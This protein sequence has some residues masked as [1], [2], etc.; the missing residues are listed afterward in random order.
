MMSQGER[1]GENQQPGPGNRGIQRG[2]GEAP[3]SLSRE[4]TDLGTNNIEGVSNTDLSRALPG[5]M[6]GETVI[7]QGPETERAQGSTTGGGVESI[8]S[9]GERVWRDQ[10]LPAEQRVL[11]RYYK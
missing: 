7:D 11:E 9:G 1:L 6:I 4:M 3:M 10:F 2:P 5:D 8:G